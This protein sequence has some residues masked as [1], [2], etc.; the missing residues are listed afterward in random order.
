M[1]QRAKVF[2]PQ[3]WV[4]AQAYSTKLSSGVHMDAKACMHKNTQIII[5]DLLM[6]T[7]VGAV[8]PPPAS[9]VWDLH[10]KLTYSSPYLWYQAIGPRSQQEQRGCL[11][12][13]IMPSKDRQNPKTSW[14]ISEGNVEQALIPQKWPTMSERAP[15]KGSAHR[16]IT[17][18]H[19]H[20]FIHSFG[21]HCGS[22]SSVPSTG[23]E[24]E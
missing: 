17:H 6:I 9:T 19:S 20:T 23:L 24:G 12:C 13:S 22:S 14:R 5:H 3:A 18:T 8:P 4:W 7:A 21:K 1:V 10:R 15:T 16:S 11:K 2:L